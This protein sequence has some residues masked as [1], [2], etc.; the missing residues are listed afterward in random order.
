M[1]DARG[2]EGQADHLVARAAGEL[3]HQRQRRAADEGI[4]PHLVQA[5]LA[6]AEVREVQRAVLV[7]DVVR[8]E[9]LFARVR[10]RKAGPPRPL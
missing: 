8:G 3:H 6:A 7:D 9:Q 2:G 1:L 5:V 10:A 4:P